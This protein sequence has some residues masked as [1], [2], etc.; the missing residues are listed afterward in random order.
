MKAQLLIM[1]IMLISINPHP[2]LRKLDLTKESC[3]K[4]GKDFQEAKPA[5]CKSRKYNF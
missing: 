3:E 4:D 1:I 5:Q 2:F